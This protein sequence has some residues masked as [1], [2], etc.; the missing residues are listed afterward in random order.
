MFFWP[1]FRFLTKNDILKLFLNDS[2]LE[3]SVSFAAP[4]GTIISGS[5]WEGGAVGAG[6]LGARIVGAGDWGRIN[7]SDSARPVG[8]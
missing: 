3:F 8:V 2:K 4:A 5:V 6:E 1:N 7:G